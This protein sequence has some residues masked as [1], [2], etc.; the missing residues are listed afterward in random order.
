[1]KNIEVEVRSFVSKEQYDKLL[2]FFRENA[3]SIKEDDQETHYFD[4]KE[5]LRIQR[6]N[7]FSKIWFKKGEIHDDWREEIEIKFDKNEFGNLEKLFS[8]L[9]LNTTIKWFRKRHEFEW[10][11]IKVCLD[12]TRGY[13]YIL[14]LEKLCSKKEKEKVLKTLKQKF[15]ELNVPITPREEFERK[16]QH[17]KKN[18]ET[19]TK[20]L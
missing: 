5:D 4:N 12:F 19:L 1:M 9:G 17:Y 7:F 2:E 18:W 11:G 6:N 16:F 14:E 8:A 3:K 15:K 13:G 10:D 20:N